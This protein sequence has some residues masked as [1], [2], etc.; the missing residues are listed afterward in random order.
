MINNT[1]GKIRVEQIWELNRRHK[2]VILAPP[3][4]SQKQ[5]TNLS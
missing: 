3:I 5:F 1:T 2:F 4:I